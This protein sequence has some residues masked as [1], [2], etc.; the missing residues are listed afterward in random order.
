MKERE[1]TGSCSGVQGEVTQDA[2]RAGGQLQRRK[3][4]PAQGLLNFQQAYV[5]I[6]AL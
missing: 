5:L 6:N 3:Q 4:C 1:R 2:T